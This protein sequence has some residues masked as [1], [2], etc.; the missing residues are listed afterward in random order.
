MKKYKLNVNI[1]KIR[2][3][4]LYPLP[5][6]LTNE[7]TTTT[8]RTTAMTVARQRWCHQHRQEQQH[9]QRWRS[10]HLMLELCSTKWKIIKRTQKDTFH[11]IE[12]DAITKGWYTF[13]SMNG[14]L[15]G[16]CLLWKKKRVFLRQ[17]HL[18]LPS[19]TSDFCLQ[20]IVHH[21]IQ[22]C[23]PIG[24]DRLHFFYDFTHSLPISRSLSLSLY[25]CLF[26]PSFSSCS[27]MAIIH[28]IQTDSSKEGHIKRLIT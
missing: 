8:T 28:F 16:L 7:P 1:K 24:S 27:F 20:F 3:K 15:Q 10:V 14:V 5:F 11:L 4:K 6:L 9:Q 17:S 25:P 26:L 19:S 23:T 13:I 22:I 12:D 2:N 21:N 18:P